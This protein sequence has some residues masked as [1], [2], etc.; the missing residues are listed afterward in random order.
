[1]PAGTEEGPG[2]TMAAVVGPGGPSGPA[3]AAATGT[4]PPSDGVAENED[5]D[6]EEARLEPGLAT[7]PTLE[8]RL[9][10]L[11]NHL[12]ARGFATA[13]AFLLEDRLPPERGGKLTGGAI[14]GTCSKES[15]G[16]TGR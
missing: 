1:M 9:S 7:G 12:L 2:A 8:V 16:T 5:P 10:T 13:F 6:K 3:V 14:S 4:G 11:L 15:T